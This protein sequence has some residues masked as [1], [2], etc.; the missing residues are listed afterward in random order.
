M[1]GPPSGKIRSAWEWPEGNISKILFWSSTAKCLNIITANHKIKKNQ[2]S[3][4]PTFSGGRFLWK[5]SFCLN[6]TVQGQRK[7][8]SKLN[9]YCS[10]GLKFEQRY[11]IQNWKKFRTYSG[12]RPNRGLIRHHFQDD[13]MWPFLLAILS[14]RIISN[15]SFTFYRLAMKRASEIWFFI[16]FA[17]SGCSIAWGWDWVLHFLWYPCPP[18]PSRWSRCPSRWESCRRRSA[19]CWTCRCRPAPSRCPPAP[20]VGPC[21]RAVRIKLFFYL[22]GQCHRMHIFCGV[23]ISK[24]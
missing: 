16:R 20:L 8:Y 1:K 9:M 13:L 3:L 22:K 12:W 23:A 7:P 21:K 19:R 18:V 5:S 15:S 24:V 10:S 17:F 2:F 4:I 6:K 11:K 14:L